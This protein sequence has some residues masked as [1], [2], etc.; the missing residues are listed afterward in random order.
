M[1][2]VMGLCPAEPAA[3]GAKTNSVPPRLKLEFEK[4]RI[5]CSGV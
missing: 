3:W 4:N 1:F 5:V 2:S